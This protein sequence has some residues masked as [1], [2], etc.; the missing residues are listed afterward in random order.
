MIT[1]KQA[2]LWCGGTVLPEFADVAFF[3]A[4]NDSRTIEPDQLF[5]ALRAERD[6]RLEREKAERAAKEAAELAR[7]KKTK[8]ILAI[9]LPA[10]ALLIAALVIVGNVTKSNRYQ[11][12]ETLLEA[13][14]YE[15]AAELFGQLK[16]YKDS[17]AKLAEAELLARTGRARE[18]LAGKS[19]FYES[20]DPEMNLRVQ[21]SLGDDGALE[22]RFGVTG[23]STV[24]ED[25]SYEVVAELEPDKILISCHVGV[26]RSVR[27]G[28]ETEEKDHQ[29]YWVVELDDKDEIL[30]FVGAQVFVCE[31]GQSVPMSDVNYWQYKI[32]MTGEGKVWKVVEPG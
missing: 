14:Q 9:A 1:L 19:Y 8:I 27:D 6:A 26:L 32:F 18:R 10:L 31:E 23:F 15:E 25:A 3:G 29:E 28:E 12:A 2:A 16:D 21:M 30:N 20:P 5:V 7:Q 4:D 13:G 17:E 22:Y 24:F 11:K